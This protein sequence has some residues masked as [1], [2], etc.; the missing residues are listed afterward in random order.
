MSDG[1]YSRIEKDFLGNE[2]MVH[3]DGSGNMIGASD[4]V[5]E[6]DGTIR[7]PNETYEGTVATPKPGV[8]PTAHIPNDAGKA[9][10]EKPKP[11]P[12]GQTAT[13]VIAT[14]IGAA[15]LTWAVLSFKNSH[16]PS[17]AGAVQNFPT[18]R[19]PEST[20][21]LPQEETVP[22]RSPEQFP[23]DPKPRNDED[24]NDARPFDQTAPDMNSGDDNHPKIQPNDDGSN[25]PV[26]KPDDADTQRE[27][28]KDNGSDPID[29]RGDGD[30]GKTPPS[31]DPIDIH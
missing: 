23:P 9:T 29:L 2:R 21:A 15:V 17:S 13:Y 24:P 25:P 10:P 26:D 16:S 1:G 3:Y 7:I 11:V 27:P 5:R 22:E 12:A 18:T 8:D 14:F 19:V 31:T 6:S 20:R 28:K 30:K 4:V